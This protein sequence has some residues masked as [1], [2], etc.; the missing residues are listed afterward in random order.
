MT[1]TV[2]ATLLLLSGML[3][4]VPSAFPR[5]GARQLIDNERV[6]VWDVA[7]EKGKPTPMFQNTFDIVTLHLQNCNVRVT[8]ANGNAKP[9][10]FKVAKAS[11]IPKGSSQIE[12][13]TSHPAR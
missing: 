7:W 12:Q 9:C 6:V 3:Q 2:L 1:K 10:A 11:F 8:C 13:R 5:P 4:Q